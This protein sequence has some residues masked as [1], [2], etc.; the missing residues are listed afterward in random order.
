MLYLDQK[1]KSALSDRISKLPELKRD[2]EI[3]LRVSKSP[4]EPSDQIQALYNSNLLR[5]LI[6][7]IEYNFD[8]NFY[9]LRTDDLIRR[10]RNLRV[11]D[12]SG[13][14]VKTHPRDHKLESTKQ[15]IIASYIKIAQEY[16]DLRGYSPPVEDHQLRCHVCFGTD[17]SV[18]EDGNNLICKGCSV[19]IET[20]DCTPSFKD[21]DRVNLSNRY[22]YSC[23]AHY[24]EAINCFECK[25]RSGSGL[26]EIENILREE[27]ENHNLTPQTVKRDHLYRFLTERNLSD[28]YKDVNWLYAKITGCA[29]PDISTYRNELLTMHDFLEEAFQ[30]VKHP[31]RINSL[32]VNYKLYKSLQILDVPCRKDD[33]YFLKTPIK[34]TEHDETWYDMIEYLSE[35]YPNDLTSN[36]KKR[37]R[38][39]HTY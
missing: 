30:K 25:Q 35:R 9:L 3:L 20:L 18:D 6:R 14:F 17:F 27:M 13:S 19:V 26:P 28:N 7:D 22:T 10:Y 38:L 36:G 23:R 2:L 31:D 11:K 1:I 24:I 21:S 12:V 34:Q 29:A 8:L 5:N 16:I 39:I 4:V 37:W 15:S 33:F 32:T